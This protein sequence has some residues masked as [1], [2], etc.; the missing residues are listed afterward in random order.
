MSNILLSE[1]PHIGIFGDTNAG[2]SAIFNKILGQDMSIVSETRGTTTDPVIKVMELISFGAV[3]LVDT[4]GLGDET[5][6]AQARES[7]T[8]QIFRRTTLALYIAD[9]SEFSES[10]YAGIKL[11]FEKND[12][13]HVLVFSKIDKVEDF[14]KFEEGYPNAEFVSVYD[15]QSV[16]KLKSRIVNELK[17]INT[18]NGKLLSDL[19]PPKSTVVLV[20]PI[21]S[22]AP[23]GRL[24]LPQVQLIRECLDSNI[25]CV[26]VTLAELAEV[27]SELKRVD[28]VITDS[29][30]FA[31][32]EKIV[33]PDILLTSFSMLFAR[34]K[35]DFST[36]LSGAAGIDKLSHGDKILI[37]EGC[38]HNTSHED[39]GTVKIPALLKKVTGK[40][41]TFDIMQGHDFPGGVSEYALIIH[42]G[43]CMLTD[44][45][46]R[47]RIKLA[48]GADVPITNYGMAIAKLTG[49]SERTIEV[50]K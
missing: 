41:L 28:L 35:G 31:E 22:E 1:R 19:L 9:I 16:E 15:E 27:L 47:S 49:I 21:D 34:K 39:I 32:V 5:A 4:A 23:K 40:K 13:P 12:I 43:G 33:S 42:C 2:K 14:Q 18:D 11:E 45:E 24:I 38:S 29:Q 17:K 20:V 10:S 3:A 44:A 37:A 8:R 30:A 26:V 46:M 36:L 25:K 6:L 50:F 7:K 48:I